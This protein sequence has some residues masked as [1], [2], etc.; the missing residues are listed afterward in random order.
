MTVAARIEEAKLASFGR[1]LTFYL[2][3][4]G[5]KRRSK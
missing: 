2:R 5:M 4:L 3:L 1:A